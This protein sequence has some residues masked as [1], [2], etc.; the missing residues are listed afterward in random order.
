M[1]LYRYKIS[2]GC[3]PTLNIYFCNS[4]TILKLCDT[5]CFHTIVS[6]YISYT[7][8]LPDC[9]KGCSKQSMLRTC[10]GENKRKC[11]PLSLLALD[12]QAASM[13]LRNRSG[14]IEAQTQSA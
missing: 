3:A 4:S 5:N 9:K 14:Q 12:F 1:M 10:K 2:V 8:I 11:T 13:L 6:L 7:I